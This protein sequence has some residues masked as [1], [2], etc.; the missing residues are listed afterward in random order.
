[1]N[2]LFHIRN[3]DGQY[4]VGTA[5]HNPIFGKFESRARFS[6]ETA[7]QRVEGLKRRGGAFEVMP[8]PTRR[9]Q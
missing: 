8:E 2:Q 9:D 6:E 4:Y 7:K 1:M 3:E 5:D